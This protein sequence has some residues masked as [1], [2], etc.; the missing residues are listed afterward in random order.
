MCGWY[1]DWSGCSQGMT[2]PPP[3]NPFAPSRWVDAFSGKS[4]DNHM[5]PE[6]FLV[7][8]PSPDSE[9]NGEVK[10]DQLAFT[11]ESP[12]PP[13][14]QLFKTVFNTGKPLSGRS[15]VASSSGG[16]L[17]LYQLFEDPGFLELHGTPAH[18]STWGIPLSTWR[19]YDAALH[20]HTSSTSTLLELNM[21]DERD[22]A[23]ADQQ[24]LQKFLA[25][26][27]GETAIAAKHKRN[28]SP[29]P[30]A[31]PSS[32]K[33][34]SDA[35]KKHSRLQSPVAEMT[36]DSPLHIRLVVHPAVAEV[37]SGL[38]QQAVSSSPAR[39]PIKGAGQD[40][41][42]SNMPPTPHPTL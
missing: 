13:Q 14:L 40:L 37:H 9:S 38:V 42:S 26:Q 18:Q 11:L 12:S 2:L 35:P 17:S 22:T 3:C 4:P 32:K 21:L 23:D 31:G 8:V 29:L 20:A 39:T 33:I 25:L 6:K 36:P 24:E 1:W 15:I 34:R 10:Q 27:Q 28:C 30:V 5:V 16:S 7:E 41:L 19:E